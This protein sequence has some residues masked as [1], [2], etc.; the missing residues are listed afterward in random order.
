MKYVWGI[1]SS[2]AALF[3]PIRGLIVCAAIFIAIDFVT[4]VMAGR[5]RA[6]RAGKPWGFESRRAWD[7]VIKLFF[8]LAGIVLAW[9]IDSLILDFMQLRL[10]RLFTGF[11]CG[12]EFWSY[13]ENA[14][15]I[16]NHPLFRSLKRFMKQQLDEAIDSK[17]NGEQQP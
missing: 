14:A 10:A 17:K 12:V 2:A 5:C 3:I 9:L 1:V 15:E 13:L 16:S 8:V 4:G 7:T 11:V 6:R